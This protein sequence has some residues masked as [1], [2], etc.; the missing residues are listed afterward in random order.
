VVLGRTI[1]RHHESRVDLTQ[2]EKSTVYVLCRLEQRPDADQER[3]LVGMK[4]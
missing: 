3:E 4:H 1:S 2:N